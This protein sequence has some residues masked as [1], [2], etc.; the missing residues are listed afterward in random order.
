[1]G[2][3]NPASGFVHATNHLPVWLSWQTSQEIGRDL[4][5]FVHLVDGAG[6]IVAQSDQR[7]FENR[8]PTPVW[9]VG[10]V[11]RDLVE[12]TL[13]DQLQ[14]GDY[15]IRLGL[16]DIAGRAPLLAGTVDYWQAGRTITVIE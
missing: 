5:V 14:A 8:W 7:T 16:Y 3:L 13:P 4:T 6:K 15:A 9:Q 11:Y 2:G 10:Q 1:M 12:I